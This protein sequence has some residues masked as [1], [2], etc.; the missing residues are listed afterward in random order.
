MEVMKPFWLY[1]Y[2]QY[3]SN[4]NLSMNRNYFNPTIFDVVIQDLDEKDLH[5]EIS[6]LLSK[7]YL[8]Q[9]QQD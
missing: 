7:P 9:L 2:R 6:R 4:L 8:H 3:F 1:D 5:N